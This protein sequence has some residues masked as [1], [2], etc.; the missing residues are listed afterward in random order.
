MAVTWS[1]RSIGAVTAVFAAGL[2]AAACTGGG[3]GPSPSAATSGTTPADTSGPQ[4][5]PSPHGVLGAPDLA[6]LPDPAAA[7]SGVDTSFLE[8]PPSPSPSSDPQRPID[9]AAGISNLDHLI[10]IVMENRSFD[11]YF[12]TFPGADGFPRDAQGRIDVCLPDPA[13][14]GVCRRPYRDTNSYDQAGPHG[15]IA[16]KIDIN[17]GKMDGFVRAFRQIGNGCVVAANADTF[18][19]RQATPGPNGTPDVMGYHTAAEIPN[20]WA[21]AKTYTLN[22]RMFAPTDSWTLPSHLFLTSGWSASCP[23][24]SNPMSCYSDQKFP[25]NMWAKTGKQWIPADGGPRPYIWGDL[26]W[27]LYKQGVS[28]A[29]YVGPGTCVAPPCKDLLGVETA[30]V[31]NALPGFLSVQVTGQLSNIRPNTEFFRSAKDGA[32]PSV[33][34]VM[35]VVGR[36]EHPPSSIENGMSFVTQAVNAVMQGPEWERSAIFLTWDDWGGF[37]DHVKP[38]VVD[39]NGWGLRVPSM[40]ISPWVKPGYIDSQTLSFDAYLK[41]IEDR[42]LGGAR[43]DPA[44]DGWPDSR[45]TVRE[46]VSILGDLADDFDFSQDPIP[47]LI[48]DPWPLR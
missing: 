39:E 10:F 11:E 12:G 20:Y 6:D 30:P 37:Y 9:P 29:Y 47:P 41:L 32:L 15:E 24:I 36:S 26:T 23:D 18:P 31:Q 42:F 43:I 21:Y 3:A 27:L 22:D 1:R 38:P 33:S 40:I 5:A 14:P 19:C 35:P 25:G 16:S 34:W 46:D 4:P 7:P 2:I 28:W 48:L 13:V 17:G 44:T 45:P 8:N